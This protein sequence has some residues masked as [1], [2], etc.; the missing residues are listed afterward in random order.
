M[1][2]RFNKNKD[3][4]ELVKVMKIKVEMRLEIEDE[5][6][7]ET[8]EKIKEKHKLRTDEEVIEYFKKQ[9][10]I[11]KNDSWMA[12]NLGVDSVVIKEVLNVQVEKG[13]E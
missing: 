12:D 5:I 10:P 2:L 11:N 4:W 1:L 6:D 13:E 3:V 9:F 7:L 8:F